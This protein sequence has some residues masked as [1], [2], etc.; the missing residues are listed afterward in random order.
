MHHGYKFALVLLAGLLGTDFF[1]LRPLLIPIIPLPVC[2]LC[3]G[4]ASNH[5]FLQLVGRRDFEWGSPQS[6]VPYSP[7]IDLQIWL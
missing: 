5:F 6:P 7:I 3:L 1:S 2:T 4:V